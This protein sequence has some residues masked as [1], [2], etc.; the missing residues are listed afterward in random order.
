MRKIL[1]TGVL[2]GALGS[3]MTYGATLGPT[4]LADTAARSDM[5][6]VRALITQM[7]AQKADVNTP[8]V[9]GTTALHW[10]AHYDDLDTVK[11][12]LAAG[13]DAD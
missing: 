8:Q 5:A 4:A 2:A 1:L 9:D 10:A 7:T 3:L 12:L 13:A 11:A 6:G